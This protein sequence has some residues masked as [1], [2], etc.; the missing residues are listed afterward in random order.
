MNH[1]KSTLFNAISFA[2]VSGASLVSFC[3]GA[4]QRDFN[5]PADAAAKS[6]PEYA[7]QANVQIVAPARGLEGVRTAPISGSHDARAALQALLQGTGLKVV[8]D[9][10]TVV[11]LSREDDAQDEE[12]QPAA[13]PARGDVHAQVEPAAFAAPEAGNARTLDAVQVTGSRIMRTVD[14]ETVQPIETI[15]RE[16]V[17]RSGLRSVGDLLQS[18]P[19]AGAPAASRTRV[20]S[21]S[22]EAGGTY[23]DLRNIGAQR[24]LI[25]VNGQRLGTT[26]GGYADVSLIPSATVERV[27]ILKDGAS[28]IYGSDAIAGVV[29]IITRRGFDGGLANAYFGQY[30]EG[31]GAT[32]SADLSWGMKRDRGWLSGTLQYTDEDPVWASDRPYSAFPS[33]V[34]HPTTGLS[35]INQHGTLIDPTLGSLTVN[36]GADP[37]NIA[38]YHRTAVSDYANVTEQQTLKTG[39]ERKSAFVDGGFE[40]NERLLLRGS[41]LYSVRDTFRNIPGY[42]YQSRVWG[43]MN[44]PL[45]IDSYYNPLGNQSGVA[46][47]RAVNYQRRTWEVPR[48]GNNK[49][50]TVRASMMLEGNFDWGGQTLYWDAGYLFNRL[51]TDKTGTGDLNLR[52]VQLAS[53]PSYYNTATGRVECGSAAAPIAY[54]SGA[55]QCVPWNPLAPYGGSYGGT[56]ADPVLRA[57]LVPDNLDRGET[58]T[59]SFTANL[60]GTMFALP[61]GDLAFAVG[62]EARTEEGTFTPSLQKQRGETTNSRKAP[63]RGDYRANEVYAELNIPL[64]QDLPF[65]RSLSLDVASRY[66]DYDVFGSTTNSKVGLEWRPSDELLVRANWGQGFRAPTINDLFGGEQDFFPAYTDPCDSR[67]GVARASA[68]CLAAVPVGYRQ[69]ASG[70]VPAG[71]PNVQSNL[72]FIS[73]SNPDTKPETSTTTTVGFVYSPQWA[74]GLGITLD[75]WKIDIQHAIV[76]NTPTDILNDC[77]VRNVASACGAFKRDPVTGEITTLNYA[78]TNAG[79]LKTSGV[80]LG[81][82]YRLPSMAIGDIKLEW[83][84]S[85]T[86]YRDIKSN[87]LATTPVNHTTGFGANFRLRSNFT[88]DWSRG[89]FGAMW[90]VRYYSGIKEAC[91]FDLA[92]GPECDKPDFVSPY[93]GRQPLR[94]VGPTVFNDF[95]LRMTLPWDGMVMLGANNVLG[96]VGSTLY[97]RPNSDF[98]YYGGFDLG[99]LVYMQYQ[100]KF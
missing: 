59:R 17:D 34:R 22:E 19:A 77:Y 43:A 35:A 80:D 61:A 88:A 5:I 95:Q 25:L 100:Q 16:D 32:K 57:F 86:R 71:S 72:A 10:G 9:D 62:M 7:R 39:M 58:R 50:T 90:R 45:S 49:V 68:V 73:G 83:N 6:L 53:G 63:T 67:F 27:E 26:T 36:A 78:F 3:A 23:I 92:G 8:R 89:M 79:W 64:L 82:R 99:R 33:T 84:S 11:T 42:P 91:A 31:D 76:Q 54:G 96:K 20:Q 18:S 48:S 70:G 75:W 15:S 51:R 37:R 60:S 4:Q 87:D 2:L 66:S 21:D 74:D 56:L 94:T 65:A 46:N 97:S 47:P 69:V 30:S 93:T 12:A 41:A 85:Y 28:A 44:A 55:G 38:N 24:T 52:N 29:N 98:S 13:A 81:M 14:V 1:R 40:I